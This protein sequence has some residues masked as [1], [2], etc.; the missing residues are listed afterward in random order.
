MYYT[1]YRSSAFHDRTTQVG[2]LFEDIINLE[3]KSRCIVFKEILG[4]LCIP[5]KLVIIEA[6]CIST[7]KTT[8]YISREIHLPRKI[9]IRI[10]THVIIESLTI[11]ILLFAV[12]YQIIIYRSIERQSK[13]S[14]R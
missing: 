7:F 14:Q 13:A 6:T 5:N 9:N 3:A 2:L 10:T 8:I 4:Y 1:P 11:T 12:T